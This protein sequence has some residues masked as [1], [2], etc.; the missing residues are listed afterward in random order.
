[1]HTKYNIHDRIHTGTYKIWSYN[2]IMIQNCT[3][4]NCS[5]QGQQKMVK[6]A[7]GIF[8]CI[9]L[10][11]NCYILIKIW[12]NQQY[13]ITGSDNGLVLVRQQAI[14]RTNDGLMQWHIYA[15]L[16]YIWNYITIG[17]L[18]YYKMF[19]WYLLVSWYLICTGLQTIWLI[20]HMWWKHIY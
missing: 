14:I 20:L 19:K 12:S 3:C 11:E 18:I 4:S 17:R 5:H 8:K 7:N 2:S 15:W 16:V 10:H 13:S 1:M 9:F 6:I